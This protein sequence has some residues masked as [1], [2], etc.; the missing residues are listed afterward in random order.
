M[1]LSLVHSRNIEGFTLIELITVII[2]VS[3][4]AVIPFINMPGSAINLDGQAQQL[5][6]DIR[7]RLVIELLHSGFDVPL[8]LQQLLVVLLDGLGL[9]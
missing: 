7:I 5:A 1:P 3:V 9:L 6:N 4:L 8:T 2:V